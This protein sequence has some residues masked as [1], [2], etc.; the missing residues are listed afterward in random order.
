MSL[1]PRLIARSPGVL[2]VKPVEIKEGNYFSMNGQATSN[3]SK[4]S[5]PLLK[6]DVLERERPDYSAVTRKLS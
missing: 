3:L 6:S 5:Y 1:V 2:R 4:N